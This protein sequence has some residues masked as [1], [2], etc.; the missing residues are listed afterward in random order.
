MSR[1][2]SS[3]T[4]KGLIAADRLRTRGSTSSTSAPVSPISRRRST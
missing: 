4:M 2:A 1:I 3:P